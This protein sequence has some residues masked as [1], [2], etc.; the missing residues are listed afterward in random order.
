M[1]DV[2]IEKSIFYQIKSFILPN[3]AM[4]ADISINRPFVFEGLNCLKFSPSNT[5]TNCFFPTCEFFSGFIPFHF[6][7]K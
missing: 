6:R 5:S 3:F 1:I 2:S 4:Y 7:M